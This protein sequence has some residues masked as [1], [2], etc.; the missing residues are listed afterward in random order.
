M[1]STTELESD[2]ATCDVCGD[3]LWMDIEILGRKRTVRCACQCE[4][5]E[6]E[7]RKQMEED[8]KTM[9]RLEKL[10]KYSLM[11]DR[12]EGCTLENWSDDIGNETL[13]RIVKRYVENWPDMYQNN[14]GLLIH[15]DPG[16]G[17]THAAFTI[18]NEIIDKY[19][20]PV[21]A[22]NSIGLL[23]RI[24]ETYAKYGDEAE[25]D[26]IN[27]LK[28]AKLLIIDDL[29]AEKKSIWSTSMLYQ[30]IDSR[31]R[32]GKPMF[33][34]TNL[35]LKQLKEKLTGDDEVDRNYD[36]IVEAC[37]PVHVEGESNRAKVSRDKKKQLIDI[38]NNEKRD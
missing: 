6:R 3:D 20:I 37:Q 5:Q 15:G 21:I 38:L 17:K 1:T 22:I 18:A 25:I 11:D 32:S 31:Y 4:Q 10:R 23:S 16:I 34:T 26:I 24:K 27:T 7:K 14:I 35:T 28:N 13:K 2:S 36:R 30:I 33:I 19:K 9:K 29:G 8:Q 12:F